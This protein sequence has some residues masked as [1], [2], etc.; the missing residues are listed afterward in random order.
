MRQYDSKYVEVIGWGSA[1]RDPPTM[2]YKQRIGDITVTASTANV[3]LYDEF[4]DR[5]LAEKY[6]STE[7]FVKRAEA[8]QD[9][10]KYKPVDAYSNEELNSYF[11]HI[12]ARVTQAN[13]FMQNLEL[14][15]EVNSCSL[16]KRKSYNVSNRMI[17][18][19][20]KI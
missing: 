1:D 7:Q 12:S 6:D 20:Y 11:K 4:F 14:V 10:V 9:I 19:A 2:I 16:K 13:E 3:Y 18:N 8:L 17:L 15:D 5:L